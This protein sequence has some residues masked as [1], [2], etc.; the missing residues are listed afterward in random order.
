MSSATERDKYTI[1]ATEGLVKF[2]QGDFESGNKI[3]K[4]AISGFKRINDYGA[5]TI[6]TFFLARE[7]LL[8]GNVDRS[9]I[10]EANKMARKYDIQEIISYIMQLES[11]NP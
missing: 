1:M 5:A 10:E 6:A 7:E 11:K 2:R 8:V 9:N 4:K 3:Y